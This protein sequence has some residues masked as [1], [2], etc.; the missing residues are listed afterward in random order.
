M[1]EVITVGQYVV[2]QRR[3]FSKLL[4]FN[5]L[6]TT[7]QMGRDTIELKNIDNAKWF[8]T[9]KM[10]MKEVGKKR[11][12][13]L[14]VCDSTTDWKEVLKTIDSGT[15]NRNIHDDGQVIIYKNS[16]KCWQNTNFIYVL[17]PNIDKRRDSEHEGEVRLNRDHRNSRGELKIV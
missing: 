16:S 12:Y 7:V 6:E 17:V 2:L 10:Q 11:L 9:F 3:E 5:N 13:S 4:K 15:D 1:E 14:E 8:T